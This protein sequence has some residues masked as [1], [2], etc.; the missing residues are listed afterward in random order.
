MSKR[1][2]PQDNASGSGTLD[3][4]TYDLVE[5]KSDGDPFEKRELL[6][7]ALAFIHYI[8]PCWIAAARAGLP[9]PSLV[10]FSPQPLHSNLTSDGPRRQCFIGA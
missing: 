6:F 7:R 3:S 10:V 1:Y 4:L 2:C 8:S 5:L 9:T